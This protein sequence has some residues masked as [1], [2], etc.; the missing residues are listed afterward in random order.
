MAATWSA[1]GTNAAFSNRGGVSGTWTISSATLG[2]GDIYLWFTADASGGVGSFVPTVTID[3]NTAPQQDS[4]QYITNLVVLTIHKVACTSATGT[5][6]I[7]IP[8]GATTVA[9][10]WGLI[11]GNGAPTYTYTQ[12]AGIADPQG[13]VTG[14]IAS[15]G[16]GVAVIAGLFAP[17]GGTGWSGA[18]GNSNMNS[19]NTTGNETGT[20]GATTTT[21]SASVTATGWSF[22]TNIMSLVAF[23]PSASTVP[24]GWDYIV[25]DI[26]P[27]VARSFSAAPAFVSPFRTAGVAGIAWQGP[28]EPAKLPPSVVFSTPP[29]A[30]TRGP[31][32]QT[33]GWDNQQEPQP[34]KKLYL[35]SAPAF[36]REPTASPV[37][38]SGM[39][40]DTLKEVDKLPKGRFLTDPA[41]VPF[42]PQTSTWSFLV[43]DTTFIPDAPRDWPPGYGAPSFS[44]P[45]GISGM[46]WQTPLDWSKPR[47][48][49][50]T[51]PAYAVNVAPVV[52]TNAGIPW[53]EPPDRDRPAT[54]VSVESPIAYVRPPTVFTPISGIAW[55]EPLDLITVKPSFSY[56]PAF[57]REILAPVPI[58][59]IAWFEPPPCIVK[60]SVSF[61]EAP[62]LQQPIVQIAPPVVPPD[63]PPVDTPRDQSTILSN[64]KAGGGGS[65]FSKRELDRIYDEW[66]RKKPKI[67]AHKQAIK[68]AVEVLEEVSAKGLLAALEPAIE[69]KET[70]EALPAKPLAAVISDIREQT[71][72]LEAILDEDEEEIMLMVWALD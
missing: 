13:P 6:T 20:G 54:K 45:V 32:S 40:W 52:N 24:S 15:N 29:A 62:A 43:G 44:A 55:Q 22:A 16:V 69:L 41:P 49:F 10:C 23:P 58:S 14:T 42:I 53:F 11:T 19:R 63:V 33:F 7:N 5:I 21:A 28:R 60:L 26:Y 65:I 59:G 12:N 18:T 2:T 3:G 71:R 46:A 30:P 35:E 68:E 64:H 72:I 17:A 70:I 61:S 8:V 31:T 50:T 66:R 37:G 39:A 34:L 36:G 57:G 27:R 67:P 56:P 38:I 47:I 9:A 4:T 25:D 51:P 1:T 48:S